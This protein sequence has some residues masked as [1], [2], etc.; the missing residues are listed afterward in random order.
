MN[1]VELRSLGRCDYTNGKS[2]MAYYDIP[3]H[4]RPHKGRGSE[5]DRAT[6]EM[7][8]R[9]QRDAKRRLMRYLRRNSK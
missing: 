4:L 5:A 2:I 1:R 6:Y 8:W 7:G 9:E 3:D